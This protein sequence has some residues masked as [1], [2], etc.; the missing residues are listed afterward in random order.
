M[1][2][3]LPTISSNNRRR[4]NFKKE[5]SRE[6]ID[7]RLVKKCKKHGMVRYFNNRCPKCYRE[8]LTKYSSKNRRKK[9]N[10][11]RVELNNS[12]NYTLPLIRNRRSLNQNNEVESIEEIPELNNSND[13]TLPSIINIRSLN[14]NNKV[15]SI[16]EIPESDNNEDET[17]NNVVLENIDQE[18]NTLDINNLNIN[19]NLNNRLPQLESSRSRLFNYVN[20]MLM[21]SSRSHRSLVM[22]N[23]VENTYLSTYWDNSEDKKVTNEI[24]ETKSNVFKI[25]SKENKCIICQ[26]DY[27]E[28]NEGRILECMH[29][30]HRDCIDKWFENKNTCPIC[31]TSILN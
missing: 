3:H 13:Y 5:S 9:Y 28:N 27:I 30:Y 21:E 17:L 14:Q 12:N 18:T 16:E 22:S 11:Y 24:L 25:N 31:R 19:I 6:E 20:P 7:G 29:Y 26:E 15:E 2:F 4:T 1:S 8:R 23:P 10:D